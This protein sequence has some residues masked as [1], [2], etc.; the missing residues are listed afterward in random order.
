MSMIVEGRKQADTAA[1]PAAS[2]DSFAGVG[3]YFAL[4]ALRAGER[5]VDLGSGSGKE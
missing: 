2:I 5:V 3:Y 1:I 4:A